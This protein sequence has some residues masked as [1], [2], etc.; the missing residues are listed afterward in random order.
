MYLSTLKLSLMALGAGVYASPV[1]LGRASSDSGEFA[2]LQRAAK[3]SS[4]AYTGCTGSAFDVTITKQLNDAATNTQGYI[5]YSKTK[6]RIS[7]VIRGS[8]TPQ[9]ILNDIDTALTTVKLSGVEFPS[10]VQIMK[11]ITSPWSAIHEDVITEVK[12]LTEQYPDYTLESTG[13]S[14]GGAMTY[15]SY[16]ALSQNF[17]DK[18][19]TSNALAAFPIGNTAFANFGSSQNGLLRRG[20]NVD[21]GVPNMYVSFPY[22]FVHYGKEVYS[23][24]T[25]ATCVLC[26][27]E[28]DTQCSAGDGDLGVTAGHFS[29]FGI[30]LGQAGC[31]DL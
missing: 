30:E 11:G 23:H 31:A 3:L 22:N 15:M 24:G 27:G 20:T 26:D 21:D 17:P 1:L 7:V 28:R 25:Q 10:G 19:I 14:L 5:G 4:A 8:T 29:S 9:D 6:A 13:H 2:E 18:N 16:I 12:S